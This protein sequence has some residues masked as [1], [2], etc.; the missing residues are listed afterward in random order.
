LNEITIDKKKVSKA[1]AEL[2]AQLDT[3]KISTNAE[4]SAKV[5]AYI[6]RLADEST[7]IT[8]FYIIAQLH[9]GYVDKINYYISNTPQIN[10]GGDQFAYNLKQYVASKTAAANTSL[11]AIQLNGTFNKT[12]IS[13]DSISADLSGKFEIPSADAIRIAASVNFTFTRN[14][15]TAFKNKFN[16]VFI[17]R[18]FTSK[19]VDKVKFP[20]QKFTSGPPKM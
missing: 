17:L 13:V 14:E 2:K 11:A 3:I 8:G 7:N 16:N 18:Y 4:V 6:S 9:P 5:R 19:L 15:T 20:E 10:I 1:T 12:K